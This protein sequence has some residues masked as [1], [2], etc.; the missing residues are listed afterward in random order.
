VAVGHSVDLRPRAWLRS[1]ATWRYVA[2]PGNG[3]GVISDVTV[4]GNRLVAVGSAS[5]TRDGQSR[6]TVWTSGNGES[7]KSTTL[8]ADAQTDGVT[9]FTAVVPA[10]GGGLLAIGV[11][12]KTDKQGDAVVFRSTDG[13]QWQRVKATGLDGSGTQQVQRVIAGPDGYTAV[14]AALNGAVTGPAVWTS[15]DG[16]TWQPASSHP[17]G[18]PTLW[19]VAR[20]PDGTLLVCGSVGTESNPAVDCWVRHGDTWDAMPVAAAQ[21]SPTTRF[22]YGLCPT[23][24]G[25]VAVGVGLLGTTVDA[26]VWT[27]TVPGR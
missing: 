24:G 27:L 6:P 16:V 23:P 22:I 21:G 4:V 14:G 1:G 19:A 3:F 18:T 20:Q 15:T 9:G 10:K 11:D 8:P 7:W 17:P 5:L 12:Q 25:I 2:L 26:A 13:T